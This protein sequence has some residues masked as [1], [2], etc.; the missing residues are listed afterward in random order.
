MFFYGRNRMAAAAINAHM[1]MIHDRILK[2]NSEISQLEEHYAFY[3]GQ[4]ESSI[5]YEASIVEKLAIEED[6]MAKSRWKFEIHEV[7]RLK[8]D[9]KRTRNGVERNRADL[10]RIRA[11]IDARRQEIEMLEERQRQYIAEN[12]ERQER[13]AAREEQVRNIPQPGAASA[14]NGAEN[15]KPKRKPIVA[16][17]APGA[18]SAANEI[19]PGVLIV[20]PKGKPRVAPRAPE[21]GAGAANKTGGK[22]SNRRTRA[23]RSKR[24]KR[25]YR[26]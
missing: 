3:N 20:R 1:K 4:V 5:R 13:E 14:A 21:P 2:L 18:A 22:R 25:R 9:L 19:E 24:S 26:R 17:R 8:E 10:Q 16:P 6:K 23:R 11:G 12:A 7:N 15:V